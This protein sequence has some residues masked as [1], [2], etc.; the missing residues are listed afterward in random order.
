MST[1]LDEQAR[2]HELRQTERRARLLHAANQVGKQAAAI[3]KLDELLPKTVDIICD[4]YG[5]YYAGI[6]LIDST[7]QWAVLRAGRGA[8]G[9]VMI[10]QGH[11]L[12][13]GGGSMV[14]WAMQARRARIALD[15]GRDR[16]HFK[17]PLLPH[18]RSEMAMPLI[19]GEKV[20][21][22]LTVQSIEPSAFSDEDI[23]TV[24]TM[25]DHLAVAISNA[26]TLKQLERA[27]AELLRTKTYEALTAST[28]QAIHWIGNKV[29]PITTT[30]ARIK[31]DLAAGEVD[32]ESLREDL[33][34]I[35]ESAREI[36][37]V[38]ENLLGPAREQ[39]PR[40]VLLADVVQSAAFHAGVP[41]IQFQMEIALRTPFVWA[42]STQLAR[43]IANLMRNALEADA[44]RL[45]I[46]IAP[47][48][49]AG[50][51]A[52]E[53]TDDGVGI[54]ADQID[55]IWAAFVSTK[56]GHAG[57]GLPACLHVIN[58]HHGQITVTSQI[59]QGTTFRMLLPLVENQVSVPT[60]MLGPTHIWLLDDDDPW[61]RLAT[62]T[63]VACGK[64]V[65]CGLQV[66]GE[67]DLIVVDEALETMAVSD[68]LTNLKVA[69]L[70]D[71]VVVVSAALL[72]EMA[73]NYLQS[74]VRNAQL[75][76]YSP[77][78]FAELLCV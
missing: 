13:V 55:H 59:G 5:F 50:F 31:S 76:P 75:K 22:A 54:P 66:E 1:H 61:S 28:T 65:Q 15:V 9:A 63:L 49:E 26:I 30:I 2:D 24:Q 62:Q 72:V 70:I 53:V 12:E 4:A 73:T 42:D 18:T 69:G 64:Q 6:F 39:Q 34:L 51:V 78:E 47:A 68:A 38:K 27:N 60:E 29:V 44:S 19:V 77:S 10:A 3:L 58:Q 23:L 7:G 48:R 32:I 52:L 14:G 25:A 21:G 35:D 56:P 74:G 57:L 37:E 36:V 45:M 71:R 67:P 43:A 8:A 33:V 41:A 40:P 17:N 16:V 11:K 20:L 46:R